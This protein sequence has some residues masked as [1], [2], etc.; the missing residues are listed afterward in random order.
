M[1]LVS[2][3]NEQLPNGCHVIL[4]QLTMLLTFCALYL[5][6]HWVAASSIGVAPPISAK[7]VSSSMYNFACQIA[8]GEKFPSLVF[9]FEPLHSTVLVHHSLVPKGVKLA[10]V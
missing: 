9:G 10:V 6:K 1:D 2:L 3:I 5:S 4:P 7:P 8:A